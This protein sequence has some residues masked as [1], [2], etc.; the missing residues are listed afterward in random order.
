MNIICIKLL[1]FFRISYGNYEYGN[2]ESSVD[3]LDVVH[4]PL[5][6]IYIF[7]CKLKMQMEFGDVA[8]KCHENHPKTKIKQTKEQD[9]ENG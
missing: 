1:L 7:R 4:P 6:Y 5:L 3:L 2:Y 8:T 9:L